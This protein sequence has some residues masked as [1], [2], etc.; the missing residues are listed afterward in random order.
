[1]WI[2]RTLGQQVRNWGPPAL[3]N[4]GTLVIFFQNVVFLELLPFPFVSITIHSKIHKRQRSV[5]VSLEA[6]RRRGMR[7]FQPVLRGMPRDGARGMSG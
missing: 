6:F 7:E 2:P 5:G 4:S 3:R 1:M